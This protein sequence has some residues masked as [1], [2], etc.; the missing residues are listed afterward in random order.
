MWPVI[1]TPC[2]LPPWK[3]LKDPFMMMSLLIP[4]SQEP[5]KD[6]DVYFR[7][8]VDELKELWS[9]GVETFN[10]STG[11]Y[12]KM[13]A[14]VLWTINDFPAYGNLSGWS[15]KGYL[16]CPTCNEDASSQKVRSKISYTGHHWYLEPSHSLRKKLSGDDV[17]Q[18]LD[19]LSTYRPGKHSN[20]KKNKRLSEELNWVRRSIL[21]ELPYRKSLKLRHNLDVMHIKKN[22]CESILAMLLSIEG[23]TKDTYKAR[24]D[25]KDMNIRTMKKKFWAFLK[26]VKFPDGYASNISGCVTADDGKI[27]KLKSHDHYVLLQRL[28][29]IAMRGFVI[30]FQW[31]FCKTLRRDE[32]EQLERDIVVILCKL[33]LIFPPASFDVMVHLAVHLPRKLYMGDQFLYKLKRYVQNKARAEGSTAKG[34]ITDE[35]LTFCSMYLTDI[36]TRFNRKERNDDGSSSKDELILNIFSKSVKPYKGGKNDGIPKKEL[37]MARW[38]VLNNCEERFGYG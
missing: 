24:Q 5:G 26:S 25:L 30:F 1:L 33:E 9:E 21:F 35:C 8:L 38:Y 22:I 27:S 2:N 28:L 19:L 11:K 6:I 4:G 31:L 29:P 36:E 7:P 13:H 17:L 16:A 14:T 37:D 32:L 23:K 12:F 15:T 34:Y 20:N 18:Q 3:C 10:A